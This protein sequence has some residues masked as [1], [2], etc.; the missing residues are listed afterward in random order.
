LKESS[1]AE[2]SARPPTTG[3]SARLTM[4]EVR[5]PSM[6]RAKMTV[7]KGAD[8]LTVSVNETATNLR[9]SSPSITVANLIAPTSTISHM[10]L[11][12]DC[13][14]WCGVTSLPTPNSRGPYILSAPNEAVQII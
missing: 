3:T 11:L 10:N 5:S 13:E 14:V 1:V 2:Q 9:L 6:S 7:K 8:D 12:S 4:S